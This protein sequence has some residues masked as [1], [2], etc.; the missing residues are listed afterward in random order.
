MINCMAPDWRGMA[1]DGVLDCMWHARH[2]P[3]HSMLPV[4]QRL[5]VALSNQIKSNPND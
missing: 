1:D 5:G 4:L 2:A 3:Q